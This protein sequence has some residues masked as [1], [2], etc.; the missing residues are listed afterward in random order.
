MYESIGRNSRDFIGQN[1]KNKTFKTRR[2]LLQY[3]P[4]LCSGLNNNALIS[5]CFIKYLHPARLFQPARLF[6]ALE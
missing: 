2:G 3:L 4:K 1:S 6:D 5:I